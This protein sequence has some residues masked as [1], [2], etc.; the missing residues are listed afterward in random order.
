MED[1][2]ML[3]TVRK[4]SEHPG[5]FKNTFFDDIFDTFP[6]VENARSNKPAVNISENEKAWE[7]N[8]A[9]PGLKK[10][11]IKI[12][13]EEDMLNVSYEQ[14]EEK[15]DEDSKWHRREFYY[16]SFNRSFLIPENVDKEKIKAE[17]KDGVLKLVLPKD[18]K[19]KVSKEIKIS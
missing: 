12:S 2:A 11:D 1:L 16:S 8:F 18:E 15:E 13:V 7:I 10:E 14:K 3:P 4:S 17:Q 6:G 19:A 5:L 9:I